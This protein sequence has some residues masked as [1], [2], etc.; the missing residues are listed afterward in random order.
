MNRTLRL[1]MLAIFFLSGGCGLVYQVTWTRMFVVAI[2]ANAYSLCAVLSA[3]MGGLAL[4][5]YLAS[6]GADRIR[7]PLRIYIA[8]ELG[9]ATFALLSPTIMDLAFNAVAPE[10]ADPDLP[11]GFRILMR[12]GLSGALLLVPTT[13][14]GAA[15][16]I[17]AKLFIED[18]E[19]MGQE[20]ATLYFAN[21]L[22]AA[23]GAFLCGF[24]L[25][26]LFGIRNA[27]LG[28]AALNVMLAVVVL[29]LRAN[30]R[31]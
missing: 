15:L 4:G 17:L 24:F 31:V 20:V 22:G 14:M 2:G 3:F 25:L 8:L 29:G 10:I 21:T 9:I 12:V 6:R 18:E 28:T 5:G 11:F 27:L 1:S 16:P 13:M 30:I 23:G 7:D 26:R 19:K